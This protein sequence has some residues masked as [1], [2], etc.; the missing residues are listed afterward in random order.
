MSILKSI[1]EPVYERIRKKV[2]PVSGYDVAP[3]VLLLV[4]AFIGSFVTHLNRWIGQYM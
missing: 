3:Y 1:T 4:I 2:P